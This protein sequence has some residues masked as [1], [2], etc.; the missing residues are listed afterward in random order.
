MVAR[1]G[2]Y[3]WLL[4]HE[5]HHTACGGLYFVPL[6]IGCCLV[7]QI[8]LCAQL[9]RQVRL[10]EDAAASPT[11]TLKSGVRKVIPLKDFVFLTW[12]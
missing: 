8:Q 3:G 1:G 5:A 6:L 2:C 11:V 12:A 4:W 7:P 9:R 10:P